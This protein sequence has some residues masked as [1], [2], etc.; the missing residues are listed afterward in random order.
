MVDLLTFQRC[1]ENTFDNYRSSSSCHSYTYDSMSAG[2]SGQQQTFWLKQTDYT[3]MLR[4]RMFAFEISLQCR[5][6]S[7]MA[8]KYSRRLFSTVESSERC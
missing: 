2:E 5:R 6:A 4:F 1:N 8:T 3:E 7:M